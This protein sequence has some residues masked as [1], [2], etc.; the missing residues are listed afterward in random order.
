[1]GEHSSS[2]IFDLSILILAGNKDMHESLDEFKFWPD[3]TT[4]SRVICPCTSEKLLYN[5]VNTLAPSFLIRSSSYLQVTRTSITSR[6]S[7]KF[8]QIG[9]R[10][11]VLAAL[12]HLEKSPKTYNG[13]YLVNT[14]APSFLIRSSS[15][16]QVTRTCMKA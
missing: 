2:F 4:N 3:T 1:M 6:T 10:T 7:L 13:R 8:G 14:L 12:G 11:A 16:L 5:V 15:F 9:L